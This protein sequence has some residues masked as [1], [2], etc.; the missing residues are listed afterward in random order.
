MCNIVDDDD[1]VS[2]LIKQL[3]LGYQVGRLNDAAIRAGC[4]IFFL[5]YLLAFAGHPTPRR[6]NINMRFNVEK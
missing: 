3:E 4:I 5:R 6:E 1:F 2:F